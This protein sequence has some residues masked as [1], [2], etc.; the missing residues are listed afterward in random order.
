[1]SRLAALVLLALAAGCGADRGEV[2]SGLAGLKDAMCAC[3][4]RGCA[5]RV[6]AALVDWSLR[7]AKVMT[8]LEAGDEARAIVTELGRCHDRLRLQ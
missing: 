8:R 6:S 7:H 1:M 2:M 5:E 3:K 4:D